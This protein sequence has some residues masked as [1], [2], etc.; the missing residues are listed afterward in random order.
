VGLD[1]FL[2]HCTYVELAIWV[3]FS[4]LE[5]ECLPY[6]YLAMG[7]L[8]SILQVRLGYLSCRGSVL[9]LQSLLA[10][11]LVCLYLLARLVVLLLVEELLEDLLRFLVKAGLKAMKMVVLVRG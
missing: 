5:L 1:L 9:D 2:L 11:A 6:F 3:C 8:F 7:L 10:V 4:L